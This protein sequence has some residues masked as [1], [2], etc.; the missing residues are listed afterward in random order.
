M[1]LKNL[2][3]SNNDY[4]K[5]V[6]L[7][8]H[9]GFAIPASGLSFAQGDYE[10]PASQS[11][12]RKSSIDT[13]TPVVP[14]RKKSRA[15]SGGDLGIHSES[16]LSLFKC[17]ICQRTFNSKYLLKKHGKD[18]FDLSQN[19]HDQEASAVVDESV[20]DGK[21]QCDNCGEAFAVQGGWLTKHLRSC[22]NEST[23]AE[24]MQDS[25]AEDAESA[26]K[27]E[28]PSCHKSFATSGGWYTKHVAKCQEKSC[29]K[30]GKTY[31]P[32]VARHLDQH[33]AKCNGIADSNPDS[34][35]AAPNESME[36]PQASS[37]LDLTDYE[38]LY[39]KGEWSCYQCSKW[40]GRRDVLRQ[41]LLVHYKK[42]IQAE[43]M[44]DS[45]D[46]TCSICQHRAPTY[47]S[48]LQH[49]SL[50]SHQKLKD[51][52][53]T[54][55]AESLFNK[56]AA[57]ASAEIEEPLFKCSVCDTGFDEKNSLTDHLVEHF[58]D[59]IKDRFIENGNK[60]GICQYIDA[61]L[62]QLTK[63]VALQHEKIRDYLPSEDGDALFEVINHV[64]E[65][66]SKDKKVKLDFDCYICHKSHK[67]KP[68]LRQHIFCHLR[69]DIQAKFYPGIEQVKTCIECPYKSSIG[70]HV[71][72]H[73]ALKHK[74]LNEFVP[75]E[76][77]KTLFLKGGGS[78]SAGH[79]AAKDKD[80]SASASRPGRP[81]SCVRC[82]SSL[83]N[84]DELKVHLETCTWSCPSCSL[85][86]RDPKSIKTHR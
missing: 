1:L 61:N 80:V 2:F 55:V 29:Q 25:T 39:K 27:K 45:T 86:L 15:E 48:L 67:S 12:K 26:S 4:E 73:L 71:V 18:C 85:K 13:S 24:I 22:L 17:Q 49:I 44:A 70:E 30:C 8:K 81:I 38:S 42:E 54:F 51:F 56:D 43:Y 31:A 74:K 83:P 63:H 9:L 20:V 60:C 79:L 76:V 19:N 35:I 46:T 66:K 32:H 78:S 68:D 58:T 37:V 33:V 6:D 50:G 7:G 57:K 11:R 52:V 40:F 82:K 53:P 5:V 3:Q 64:D 69:H 36:E 10:E 47:K 62:G 84:K 59:R 21:K 65:D 72:M 23:I 28:C 16:P 75:A 41:H 14:A 77:A 34:P